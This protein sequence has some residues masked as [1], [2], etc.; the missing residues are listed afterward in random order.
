M[1]SQGDP[2]NGEGA[3]VYLRSGEVDP[4]LLT[5]DAEVGGDAIDVEKEPDRLLHVPC[6]GS[7]ARTCARMPQGR[8][9]RAC[10]RS[11]CG[12]LS[13]RDGGVTALVGIDS[14]HDHDAVSL[15]VG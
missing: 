10:P 15:P 7:R 5:D 12:H 3:Y 13:D 14:Q 11:S 8:R 1:L 6:E 9:S 4:H 2:A